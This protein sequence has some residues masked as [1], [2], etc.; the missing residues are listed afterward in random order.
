[1]F[2]YV[3]LQSLGIDYI[4]RLSTLVGD[5][6]DFGIAR[7][8]RALDVSQLGQPGLL[9]VQGRFL[10]FSVREDLGAKRNNGGTTK[11]SRNA[12]PCGQGISRLQNLLE[13]VTHIE[14]IS[15]SQSGSFKLQ[16]RIQREVGIR[17]VR[18][19]RISDWHAFWR[20]KE[21][22]TCWE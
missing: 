2:P 21:L 4:P 19:K 20:Q 6:R 1:M 18:D 9:F 14:Q 15:N 11:L 17:A 13:D 7:P 22:K 16:A 10:R 8:L 12:H 3:I 5:E